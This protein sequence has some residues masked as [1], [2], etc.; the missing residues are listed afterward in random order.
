MR[1]VLKIIKQKLNPRPFKS[2]FQ[3]QTKRLI[4]LCF[5]YVDNDSKNVEKIFIIFSTELDTIW[6][7]TFYKINNQI[8]RKHEIG[9]R[10][11]PNDE[12][13]IALNKMANEIIQE[14]VGNFKL[15]SQDLPCDFKITYELD[16]G[17]FDCQMSYE[18]KMTIDPN[19]SIHTMSDEWIELEKSAIA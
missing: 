8:L 1:R 7:N 13:Q 18:K 19:F 5:D 15:H 9:E 2:S 12:K 11:N 6:F 10:F 4:S 16:N 17:K 14:I 3:K